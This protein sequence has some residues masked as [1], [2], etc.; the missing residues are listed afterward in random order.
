MRVIPT[1]VHGILDYLVGA[2]LIAAPWILG[3]ARGGAETWV[4]VV[5]G[6]GAIVYS[7]MT[8]YELGVSKTLSMRTHLNLDLLS[9]A[10]LAISPWLFGFNEYVYMPHLILGIMEI[11]AA[12]LTNPVPAH[13]DNRTGHHHVREHRHAH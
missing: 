3:F 1:R 9:G 8:N 10:F 6:I 7:L 11:G 4:P 13:A 5:L 2:F 12:L